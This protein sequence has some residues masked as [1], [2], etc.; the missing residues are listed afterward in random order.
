[1]KEIGK[2][3]L[4]HHFV[5]QLWHIRP[6]TLEVMKNILL[7]KM[8]GVKFEAV[9]QSEGG[10]SE[11]VR[12]G[13]TAILNISGVLVPKASFIDSMCGMKGTHQLRAE[14]Q[15]LVK[16]PTVGRIVLNIDSPGGV[17][18]G[19]MEFAEEIYEARGIKEIV[20]FVDTQ[21]A[22]AGYWLASAA[23]HIVCEPSAIIG[24]IGTYIIVTKESVDNVHIFQAGTKKLYGSSVTP[25]SEDETKYFESKVE[26]A[27]N[28]FL[29]AV[30]KYREVSVDEVRNLQAGYFSADEA[31]AWLYTELNKLQNII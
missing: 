25:I 22:S 10:S 7:Q 14:F 6:E 23:E 21:A 12:S 3:F 20:A 4:F 28:K 15:A 11:V 2:S 30:A 26:S 29:N 8:D 9:E 27:N 18:L 1:M 31:P 13:T 5:N 19:I 16:D 17:G 24:S